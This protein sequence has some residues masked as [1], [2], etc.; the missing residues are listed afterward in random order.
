MISVKKSCLATLATLLFALSGSA[1]VNLDVQEVRLRA[2]E[3]NREYLAAQQEVVKADG[4]IGQ[5][6]SGALPSVSLNGGYTRNFE[7]PSMFI[8][9][10]DGTEE[11]KFGFANNFDATLMVRQSLYAGGRVFAAYAIARQYKSYTEAIAQGVSAS[12]VLNAETLFYNVIL[13]QARL[14]VLTDALKTNT[15]NVEV[16]E[17]FYEQGLTSRFEVLRART[18]A[19]NLRPQILAA[20][21][22][23]RLSEKYLKS[24]LGLDLDA[25]VSLVPPVDDTALTALQ[26]LEWLV[27][28]ALVNRAE[29]R[30]AGLLFEMRSKAV[31]VA[32]AG[33][34]PNLAAFTQYTW[35]S[36]SDAFRLSENTSKSFTAGLTL[37]LSLFDGGRTRGEVGKAKAERRQAE[38]N[39]HSV[40][41]AVRLEV[42]QAYDRLMQA[43][44]ALDIQGETI[45]Q[46]DEG[47]RIARLRFE[48]GEGTL[49]E[50]LSAQSALSVAQS[51]E[52]EAIY[53]FRTAQA[54]L[55]KATT[56]DINAL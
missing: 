48:A 43:K 10:P 13:G 27:D 56:I 29:V 19:A 25:P 30:Q 53:A 22:N 23:V 45:A 26:D 55:R 17:K 3:F 14:A 33:Y 44:K 50:V 39:Q 5:A 34:F 32:R 4:D 9:T 21:S 8:E 42:E 47:L 31:R 41:D 38:L 37:S 35:G 24:F 7:I 6:R 11:I 28:T 49:L 54:S 20:E 46:A 51:A 36:S 52:A 12:V 15:H 2:L 1:Q 40:Q 18:E 16:V